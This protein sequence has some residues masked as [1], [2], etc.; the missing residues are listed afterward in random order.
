MRSKIL[1]CKNCRFVL[2][3]K[4]FPVQCVCILNYVT[5]FQVHSI[6]RHTAELLKFSSDE[7]L[8]DLYTK[9]AWTLDT[10]LKGVGKAFD[11]FKKAVTYVDY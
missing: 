10:N 8:E 7:Q 5:C 2:N 4:P 11:A 1:Q 9:T 6:L 3:F